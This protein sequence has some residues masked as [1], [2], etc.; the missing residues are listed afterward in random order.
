M[1][2]VIH[3][4]IFCQFSLNAYFWTAISFL[5]IFPEFICLGLPLVCYKVGLG[6]NDV[7]SN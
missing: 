7:S 5:L 3:F 2:Y 1:I 6:L 4:F